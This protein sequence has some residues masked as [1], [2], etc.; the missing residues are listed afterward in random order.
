MVRPLWETSKLSVLSDAVCDAVL[1]A[2][3][4]TITCDLF[5][6]RLLYTR[7]RSWFDLK[8]AKCLYLWKYT[9]YKNDFTH[10]TIDE[11][12]VI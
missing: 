9:C 3:K 4:N 10:L 11:E 7:S 2:S 6:P 5:R 8:H 12:N 1:C